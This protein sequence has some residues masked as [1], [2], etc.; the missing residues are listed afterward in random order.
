MKKSP[1]KW[2]IITVS[3]FFL[4]ISPGFLTD[5][6]FMDG[7]IYAV[8]SRNFALG[9]ELF[10]SLSFS[11]TLD[12]SFYGHPPLVFAIQGIFFNLST[13][14]YTERIYS[15]FTYL[16][17]G[18]VIL[19]IW[20]KI[21]FSKNYATAS[22]P[23]FIWLLAPGT[24]WGAM[25]NVLENTMTIFVLLAF[26]LFVLGKSNN[27]WYF[28]VFAGIAAFLAFMCKGPTGLFVFSIP[29]W[30]FVVEKEVKFFEFIKQ[31]IWMLL[32]FFAGFLFLYIFYNKAFEFIIIYLDRQ[33][34][35]SMTSAQTVPY[36]AF[37]LKRLLQEISVVLVLS[38]VFFA[39]RKKLNISQSEFFGQKKAALLLIFIGLSGVLPIMVSLKQSAFYILSAMPF[40]ML[41]FALLTES[42]WLKL[43]ENVSNSKVAR[44]AFSALA[45]ILLVAAIVV[46]GLQVGKFGRDK[47][48]LESINEICTIVPHHSVVSI[49][50]YDRTQWSMHAYFQRKACISLDF[51]EQNR[52]LYL[53]SS[54]EISGADTVLYIFE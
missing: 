40:F 37:I 22:I 6:M 9:T 31:S 7:I 18:I 13:G 53:V 25:N 50:D 26:F 51:K 27:K 32:G 47:L 46:N 20:K 38:V 21:S 33:L 17:S 12:K 16:V 5:G 39:L 36:R 44:T 28:V 10:G 24:S 30:Y 54:A 8:I 3:L 35:G 41:G 23:L 11:E 43:G 34:L 14:L 52:H 42:S 15:V 48:P 29:F 45:A 4:F 2:Y 49:N 19:L 1:V